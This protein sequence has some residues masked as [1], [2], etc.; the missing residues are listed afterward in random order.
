M[1]C[2]GGGGGWDGG[3]TVAWGRWTVAPP[4]LHASTP[5]SPN[6]CAASPHYCSGCV[7]AL[8]M[9]CGVVDA[10]MPPPPGIMQIQNR[11]CVEWVR[12]CSYISTSTDLQT[13]ELRH[14]STSLHLSKGRITAQIHPTA[15]EQGALPGTTPVAVLARV[16]V[17]LCVLY[18]VVV[19]TPRPLYDAF[20]TIQPEPEP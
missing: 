1:R 3:K 20:G 11:G 10:H 14:N 15:F 18:G 19:Y 5:P 13:I 9:V 8:S 7:N 12:R 16:V 4:C 2:R 6:D 17:V